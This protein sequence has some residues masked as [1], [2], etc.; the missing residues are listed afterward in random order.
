VIAVIL[1]AL[2]FSTYI[3]AESG[4]DVYKM[5]CSP[6]HGANGAGQTMIG[7]NLKLRSLASPEVQSQSDAQLAAIISQGKNRNKM[8]A[9][10][11]KLSKDQIAAV[12]KYIRSL[13]N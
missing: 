10:D 1:V 11:R 4:A 2:L 3:F 9:F 8:P 12:V 6:C 5:R 13:K 7:K